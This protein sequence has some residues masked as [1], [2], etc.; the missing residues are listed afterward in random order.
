MRQPGKHHQTI[1]SDIYDS[2]RY[3]YPPSGVEHSQGGGR[4]GRT[5]RGWGEQAAVEDH[6]LAAQG[7]RNRKVQELANRTLD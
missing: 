6:H 2:L 4:S 5:G 7:Y 1:W 3:Y